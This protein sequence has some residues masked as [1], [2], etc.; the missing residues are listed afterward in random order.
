MLKFV[1]A[2]Y[3]TVVCIVTLVKQVIPFW[4]FVIQRKLR[5]CSVDVNNQV[6]VLNFIVSLNAFAKVVK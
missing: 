1:N 2:D 4:S 6:K 5:F 3:V